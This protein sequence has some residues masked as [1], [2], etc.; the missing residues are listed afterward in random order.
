MTARALRLG[1][2]PVRLRACQDRDRSL[3]EDNTVAE[4]RA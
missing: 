4:V 3:A 1:P 2:N